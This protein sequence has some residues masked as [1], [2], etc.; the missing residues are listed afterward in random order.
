MKPRNRNFQ[1]PLTLAAGLVLRTGAFLFLAV[2]TGGAQAAAPAERDFTFFV[3]SDIHLGTDKPDAK[4]PVTPEMARQHVHGNLEEMR[5]L[6]GKPFP[7]KGD[8]KALNLGTIP[9]PRG[10]FILGDL[11]DG[12]R[13]PTK[14]GEQW[15]TFEELFP[16]AGSVFGSQPVPAFAS[17]G[18]H[19]GEAAGPQGQGLIRYHRTLQA[20]GRLAA[21]SDNGL[22]YA[23]NWDGLHII[24]VNLCAADTIDE[25]TPFRF[26]KPAKGSWN[27]PQGALTF[28]ANYLKKNVGNSGQPVIVVQHYG[29]DAFSLN[30]WNWW[31]PRQRR[32]MYDL[33]KDFNVAAILHGHNHFTEHYRW[34]E[35]KRHEAD[36]KA[37]FGDAPPADLRQFDV[38]S[39]GGVCWVFRVKGSQL[40]AAHFNGPKWSPNDADYIVK[41]LE[42][43]PA[44][45]SGKKTSP[46]AEPVSTH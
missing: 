3:F 43:L 41:S 19:D 16:P 25:Q 26:G 13:D 32:A 6:V 8:L 29:F 28:L 39:C 37:M 5:G 21:L 46:A 38:L 44:P 15:K 45:G 14:R 23:L 18:N 36:I 7:Q 11:T 40:I 17:L 1:R 35:P 31:T 9:A 30:D 33:L 42:P 2:F 22:H 34:P 24:G 4:P 20:A 10:L 27:D 12:H